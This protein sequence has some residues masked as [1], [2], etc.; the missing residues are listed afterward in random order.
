MIRYVI[1]FLSLNLLLACTNHD[2]QNDKTASQEDTIHKAVSKKTGA[3]G[4]SISTIVKAGGDTAGS[5]QKELIQPPITNDSLA[6]KI[7]TYIITK[8]LDS[9]DLRTITAEERKFQLYQTDL[10]NDGRNEVFVNFITGYFCGTGGCSI[11]LLDSDLKRITKFSAMNVPLFIEQTNKTGWKH[12]LVRSERALKELIYK[13]G[14]YPSNPSVLDNAPYDVPGNDVEVVFD[15]N[16][17]RKTY[18]F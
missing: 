12:I 10:D 11:L 8:L 5:K 6:L 7:K 17:K 3:T 2:K 15:V 4:D 18:V 13:N 14:T 16:R 1:T 9:N